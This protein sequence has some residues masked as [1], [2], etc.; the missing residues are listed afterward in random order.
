[1]TYL[2]ANK[3]IHQE[4]VEIEQLTKVDTTK[5]NAAGV[6]RTER[7]ERKFFIFP[8]NIGFAYT[9]LRQFCRPDS[10]YPEGQVNTLYF[11][12]PDLD[13]YIK[14]ASGD[15]RKNKVRIRWYDRVENSQGMVPI[16][17][18]LKTRQGFVSSKQRQRSL[19]PA[20]NLELTRLVA[21]IVDPTTL[22]N[23]LAGFGHFPEEPLRPIITTSYWRYRFTEMLTGVRVSLDY[24]IRSSMVARELGYGERDLQLRGA[25]VEVKGPTL[26][27]PLTL[28]RIRLLDTD[29]SRFSK[30]GYCVDSHLSEPGTVARLWPSGRIIET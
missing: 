27:L 18:E 24:D 12:T 30:Y 6:Q 10:E 21:G 5:I 16:F 1:M 29:W 14:S 22:I 28:R 9:L 4:R 25:V 17:L 26:E 15:F 23:T 20:Q 13:E 2:L 11:D 3:S 7:F 19:V 8:R